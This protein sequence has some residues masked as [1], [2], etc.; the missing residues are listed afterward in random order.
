[1]YLLRKSQKPARDPRIVAADREYAEWLKKRP[2]SA[3]QEMDAHIDFNGVPCDIETGRS[4]VRVWYNSQ[5]D[6]QGMSLMRLPYGEARGS[7]GADGDAVDV[8]VGM[9]RDAPEVYVVHTVKAPGFEVYDEDKCFLGLRSPEDAFEAFHQAYSEP[10]FYGSMSVWKFEDWRQALVTMRGKRLA[11]GT[12]WIPADPSANGMDGDLY[13]PPLQKSGEAICKQIGDSM[14]IDWKKYDLDEFCDGMFDEQDHSDVVNGDQTKLARIVL[15]HLDEDPHYYSGMKAAKKAGL[16]KSRVRHTMYRTGSGLTINRKEY[17]DRRIKKDP[18]Q[19]EKKTEP[20]SQQIEDLVP[21]AHLESW[22]SKHFPWIEWYLTSTSPEAMIPT[23]KQFTI[24]AAKYPETAESI[25]KISTFGGDESGAVAVS[26]YRNIPAFTG[27]IPSGG[28]AIGLN[29][30]FFGDAKEL[31]SHIK[32][33]KDS[34][35]L[36]PTLEKGYPITHEFGH[37]M[38]N[39]I[40][41]DHNN[42]AT[43]WALSHRGLWQKTKLARMNEREIWAEGFAQVELFQP[44]NLSRFARKLEEFLRVIRHA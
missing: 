15:E 4:R 38:F 34:K 23:L 44:A 43:E 29:P 24:L 14:H 5:N 40:N 2:P 18:A 31:A 42:A 41:A 26:K 25:R 27:R 19:R 16:M 20:Q 37:A 32:T 30:K 13:L 11:S 8:F 3:D 1:M 33:R 22:A 36:L 6:T 17:F 39:Q 7:L 28:T 35:Y 10:R 12:A 9:D 21:T